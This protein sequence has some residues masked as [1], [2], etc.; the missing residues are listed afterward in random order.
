MSSIKSSRDVVET[1][2]RLVLALLLP[3]GASGFFFLL[4]EYSSDMS[5]GRPVLLVVR[6]S[7][8]LELRL[9]LELR[10]VAS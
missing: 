9:K 7:S 8:K 3:E 2:D 4:R 5:T 1:D 6:I 10:M